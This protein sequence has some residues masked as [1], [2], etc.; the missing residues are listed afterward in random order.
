MQTL[1]LVAKRGNAEAAVLAKEIRARHPGLTVLA[2]GD[3]ARDLGWPCEYPDPKLADQADLVI[4]LGGDGTLIH[5]ARLLRGRA[6]PILG[7]N[8]GTLGFLT[9]IA[10]SD[11]G[12]ALD[13]A[14][15]GRLPVESRLK[16]K[17]KLVRDGKTILEDAALNDVVI[18]RGALARMSDHEL[19]MDGNFVTTYRSD[20]A[21][22]CTPTGSTAYAL[23]AGGPI[24]HP[25]VEAMV[26]APICPH[27]LTQRPL[28]VP[29]SRFLELILAQNHGDICLTL[30]GQ[31]GHVLEKGD[32]VQIQRAEERVLLLKN[33]QL[34]YFDILRQKL[35]WGER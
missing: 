31:V 35:R 14:I 4:S 2:D 20:G 17:C 23:S 26:V 6:T 27:G 25:S 5:A 15:A 3:L 33:P 18:N 13:E 7:V 19:W 22:V 28:V 8:L 1:L 11:L 10:A 32:R 29:A 34:G 9:E 12:P 24:V 30:D 16:L 21:V